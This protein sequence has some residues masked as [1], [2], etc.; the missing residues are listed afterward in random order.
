MS[1]LGR[2]LRSHDD[3]QPWSGAYAPYDLVKELIIAIAVFALIAVG[4]TILFSSPDERPSTVAQWSRQ[5]PV[6]F[7]KTATAELGGTSATAEYDPPYNHNNASAQHIGSIHLQ[8]RLGV[9]H[10]IN[11]AADYVIN[12]LR[13]IPADPALQGGLATSQA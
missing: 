13:S 7:A 3:T 6:D 10:P 1:R 4:L 9:S 12:P 2:L 5:L 11:P 8:K